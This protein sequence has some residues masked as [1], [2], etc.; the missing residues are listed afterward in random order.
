MADKAVRAALMSLHGMADK[1]KA[2]TNSN[3]DDC[4]GV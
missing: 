4:E 2:M 1:I 3:Q